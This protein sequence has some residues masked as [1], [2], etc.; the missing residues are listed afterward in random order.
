MNHPGI[1]NMAIPEFQGFE[2]CK[3]LEVRKPGIGD[4]RA[5]E[6]EIIEIR[7]ILEAY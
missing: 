2:L 1:G 3:S 5:A 6:Y 4:L 7:K